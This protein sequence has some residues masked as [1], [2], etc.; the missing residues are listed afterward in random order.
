MSTR[1]P[2]I[3]D[4]LIRGLKHRLTWWG[5]PSANP[6]VLLHGYMDRGLTWQFVV[7]QLP[8]SWSCVAPDW[9][10]FGA[11]APAPGGYWFPD[12]F[13]DLEALLDVVVPQQRARV[14]GHSMGGH[15]AS[16]YAGIRPTRLAWLANLE[17]IGL[18]RTPSDRAPTRYAEWLD[19]L[20]AGPPAKRYPSIELL[21]EVLRR[22]NPR[23]PPERARFL[24]EVWTVPAAGG[25]RDLAADPRHAF[26]NPVLHRR[27]EA[28]ACWR[29]VEIPMLLLLGELSAHLSR[30]GA[31]ASE[32]YFASIF[33]SLRQVRLPGC[34]HMMHHEDPEA[35]AR[36]IIAFERSLSEA[37]RSDTRS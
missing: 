18:P 22:R 8:E 5:E 33:R 1:T 6:V 37:A 15:V 3:E 29:A 25:E 17:G 27:E 36:E 19:Q 20:K 35:V 11:S 23:L 26:V 28:E 31:D 32:A 34:G 12:Y 24:A 9:R 13:A 14:V 10:G 7:D 21:T 16:L 4:R 30:F 2:R